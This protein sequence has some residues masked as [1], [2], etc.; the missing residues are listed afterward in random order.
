MTF[1]HSFMKFSV[2]NF[3]V[4]I[5]TSLTLITRNFFRVPKTV[6]YYGISYNFRKSY[7]SLFRDC[8]Y[9]RIL[10]FSINFTDYFSPSILKTT[11]L[12]LR[13]RQNNSE[14]FNR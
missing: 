8:F 1:K 13:N 6:F 5:T 4:L 10:K 9:P 2:I 7:N 14:F 3:E 12:G 11:P